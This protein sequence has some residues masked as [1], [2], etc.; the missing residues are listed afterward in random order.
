MAAAFSSSAL[1]GFSK[2]ALIYSIENKSVLLY[3]VFF[4]VFRRE[5]E[6]NNREPMI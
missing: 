3:Y 4:A 5:N 2:E 6:K 1:N